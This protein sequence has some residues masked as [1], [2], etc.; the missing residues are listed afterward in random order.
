MAVSILFITAM[1]VISA[2]EF[3]AVSSGQTAARIRALNMANQG[4]EQA[5]NIP[6]DNLGIRYGNGAYGDPPGTIAA[7]ATV[8]G[9]GVRT[10]VWWTR[11]PVTGRSEYKNI[12]ITV[13][14][15]KPLA[16]NVSVVSAVY[17][18]SANAN[19]GDLVVTVKDGSTN[20][21]IQSAQVNVT[22]FDGSVQRAVAADASGTAF[23]GLLPIGLT[24]V[25]VSAF[26]WLFDSAAL[27]TPTIAPDLVTSIVAY[28][29]RP[30]TAA[31]T[32]TDTAGAP[33]LDATVTLT[34]SRG[35]SR[36]SS[37]GTGGIYNFADLLPDTWQVS[38]TAPGRTSATG[39]LG[40]M[41]A[42]G[43]YA[44]GISLTQYVPPGALR[45][46]VRTVAGATIS[47]ASVSVTGPTP[48]IGAISGSPQITPTSGEAFFAS[49]ASGTYAVTVTKT[50][51]QT[52][53][54]AVTVV[55]GVQ[56]L[57]VVTMPS[58]APS[59]GNISVLVQRSNGNPRVG[60]TVTASGASGNVT[61]VTDGQ[62]AVTFAG[63]PVGSYQVSTSNGNRQASQTVQVTG[64]QTSQVTLVPN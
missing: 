33:I 48:G 44:L 45:V 25:R 13:S 9:Y 8:D 16:G 53:A 59:T 3:V 7:T 19:T 49:V 35:R 37:A 27:T 5:R 15:T 10:E 23:F 39:V 61:R 18:K 1:G 22:P 46:R 41:V 51:Y 34:D 55:S 32:V 29:Y 62:G 40:P 56:Y 30:C 14:W 12:R 38:V 60:W 54:L 64:G 4:L 17:G 20:D 2:I 63:L 47:G 43:A 58:S 36:V 11:D 31:I 28:G 50:G 26:G 21:A 52:T 6:Y 42:G 57:A 24:P